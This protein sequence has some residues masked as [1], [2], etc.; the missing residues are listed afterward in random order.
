MHAR[1]VIPVS[2]RYPC[3]CRYGKSAGDTRHDLVRYPVFLKKLKF[4]AAASEDERVT[5]LEADHVKTLLG[6][7]EQKLVDLALLHG[8]KARPLANVYLFGIFRYERE[9]TAADE[10]VIHYD[11]SRLYDVSGLQRQEPVVSRAC[12]DKPDF[13]FSVMLYFFL[14]HA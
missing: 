13:A 3:I 1:A 14:I 4:L 8:V 7:L 2:H 9:N 10:C 6:L 12:S 11:I 5:A